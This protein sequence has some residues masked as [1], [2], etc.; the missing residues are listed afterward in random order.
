MARRLSRESSDRSALYRE[1]LRRLH[2]PDAPQ[3]EPNFVIPHERIVWRDAKGRF[4]KAPLSGR[5]PKGWK[6]QRVVQYVD[7]L[8]KPAKK[9]EDP[10]LIANRWIQYRE[11][12]ERGKRSSWK[13]A[14]KVDFRKPLQARIVEQRG[15]RKQPH[16]I[17]LLDEGKVRRWS[18]DARAENRRFLVPEIF[19]GK[20]IEISLEGRTVK[21]A[22]GRFNW[23]VGYYGQRVVINSRVQYYYRDSDGDMQR[24]KFNADLIEEWVSAPNILAT[25]SE[26]ETY[27]SILRNRYAEQIRAGF[28]SR[29]A[30]FTRLDTLVELYDQGA[31]SDEDEFQSLYEIFAQRDQ[32]EKVSIQLVIL[33]ED[34]AKKT[35]KKKKPN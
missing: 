23:E 5:A 25:G 24:E 34:L 1:G 13:N 30:R 22:L 11:I 32:A 18:K 9:P 14:D 4:K 17:L 28:A 26:K 35:K 29:R 31:F 21:E 8:G 6:K 12:P 16:E 33:V 3:P 10:E 27:G 7:T 15:D 20:K 19:V 2:V